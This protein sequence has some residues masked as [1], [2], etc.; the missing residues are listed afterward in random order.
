MAGLLNNTSVQIMKSPT[1]L[2]L[3]FA[4]SLFAAPRSGATESPG[5]PG[6]QLRGTFGTYNAAPRQAD[7]RVNVDRL[8]SELVALNANTY[9]WLVWHGAA[10]WDDLQLFL[11]RA[12]QAG[13]K[14]WVSLVPPS[15]SP[16]KTKN[17]SEPFRLDYARWAAEIAKLSLQQTNVVAWSIDDFAHNLKVYTPAE[18]KRMVEAARAINPRLAFVPCVY[19]RQCT[20]ALAKAYGGLFDGILFPYRNESGEM[21]L[22][23]ASA[24]GPEVA[25]V[26]EVFGATMPVFID[27]YATKH[28]RLNEGTPEY[29]EQVMVAGRR[30]ADGV[31]IY[32]HQNP[33][34][35]PA[36]TA[37]IKRLFHEWAA[38]GQV[39]KP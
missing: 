39:A 32:C 35:Q 38:A 8:L 2:V 12:A 10:D 19:Y 25:K 36:K 6:G 9:N 26:K 33:I 18:V 13:I 15:E 16:P 24:V 28:S 34:A 17:Y 23:D 29:V 27:V 22:S 14:V 20:P 1:A 3:L 11:P 7:G 21:N 5:V 30:C 4:I 37:V 31:L